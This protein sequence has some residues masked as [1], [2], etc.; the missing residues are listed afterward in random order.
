[1]RTQ[2]SLWRIISLVSLAGVMSLGACGDDSGS[3]QDL[4]MNKDLSVS[5]MGTNCQTLLLCATQC[6][7]SA[8]CIS[9]CINAATTTAQATFS[10]ISACGL[11][12]CTVVPDGGSTVDGGGAACSSVTDT[13]PEC[14]SCASAAALGPACASTVAACEQS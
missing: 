11:N 1:M 5:T 6:G 4:A 8:S 14:V 7:S 9:T 3:K 13:S 10:A 12:A 2:N